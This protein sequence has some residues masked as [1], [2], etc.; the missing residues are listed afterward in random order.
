MA[1]SSSPCWDF[2]TNLTRT[3]RLWLSLLCVSGMLLSVRLFDTRLN[4]TGWLDFYQLFVPTA[5]GGA[6]ANGMLATL[7][8]LGW[9]RNPERDVRRLGL[10]FALS[11]VA[12]LSDRL[13][14]AWFSIPAI[15]ALGI[16]VLLRR[17]SWRSAGPARV[18]APSCRLPWTAAICLGEPPASA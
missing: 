10:L 12:S 17:L 4:G 11:V 16:F 15:C 13:Y 1:P 3:R 18:P 8:I 9:L 14:T 5:H 7:L 6:F 2:V